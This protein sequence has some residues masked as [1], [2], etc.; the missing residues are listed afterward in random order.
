MA[1]SKESM[2]VDQSNNDNESNNE[3]N[4]AN[5]KPKEP[6]YELSVQLA[7]HN[8]PARCVVAIDNNTI[9]SAGRKDGE[10]ILWKRMTKKEQENNENNENND[11]TNTNNNDN[12]NDNNDDNE[13]KKD[14]DNDEKMTDLSVHSI[15]FNG[16]FIFT[17]D[18]FHPLTFCAVKHRLKSDPARIVSGG[19]DQRA[20][21]W[22]INGNIIQQLSG[23]SNSV[24]SVDVTDE[25]AVITGSYDSYVIL[26]LI[27]LFIE[28][29]H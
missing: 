17:E 4:N 5:K 3:N 21:I 8:S 7:M 19:N 25:G 15:K 16:S 6:E 20:V 18:K 26:A 29:I 11:N 28:C 9:V 2:D 27:H 23:H 14:D 13:D 10:F 1:Q 12:N 22:D 24:N